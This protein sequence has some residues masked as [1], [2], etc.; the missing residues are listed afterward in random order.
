VCAMGKKQGGGGIDSSDSEEMGKKIASH[1]RLA[2]KHS[3]AS[4]SLITRYFAKQQKKKKGKTSDIDPQTKLDGD[5]SKKDGD[6]DVSGRGAPDAVK[7]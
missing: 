2:E 1:T 3:A 4:H 5:N 7:A 6:P